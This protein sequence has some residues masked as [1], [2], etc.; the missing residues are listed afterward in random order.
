MI[1]QDKKDQKLAPKSHKIFNR[2][3][4]VMKMKDKISQIF[5]KYGFKQKTGS[6]EYNLNLYI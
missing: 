5:Q 4:I 2:L 6:S 3:W 1:N